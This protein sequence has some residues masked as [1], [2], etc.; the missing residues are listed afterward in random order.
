ML[1][2]IFDCFILFENVVLTNELA[3]QKHESHC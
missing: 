2:R 3:S 1:E